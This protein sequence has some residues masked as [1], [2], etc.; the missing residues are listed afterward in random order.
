[1]DELAEILAGC[2]RNEREAQERL[3]RIFSP[4]LMGICIRYMRHREE[5]EDLL[6][7]TFVKIF[8]GLS[9]LQYDGSFAGWAKRIAVNGAI[10]LLK[11][12]KRIRFDSDLSE[13]DEPAVGDE[14][15]RLDANE[16]MACMSLLPDG[17]R[18]IV[19]LFTVEGF[20][21]AEVAARLGIKES[22]SRSQYSRAIRQLAALWK[23]RQTTAAM[24]STK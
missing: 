5:A 4:S 13:A 16:L 6:Q 19:N 2:R 9:S 11:K 7:D 3:Y 18:T 17:Y 21:H 22:T 24:A 12:K 15:D 14:I 1:M 20:S 8:T 10:N 23:K